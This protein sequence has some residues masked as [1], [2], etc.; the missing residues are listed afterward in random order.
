MELIRSNVLK[1]LGVYKEN[2]V[3]LRTEQ[4]VENYFSKAIKNGII[5]VDTETNNSLDPLTCLLMGACIY[6]PGEKNAYIP[7]HHTDLLGNLLPN[8]VSEEFLK[9]QFERL[10]DTFIIM[11]NGKFDY[12]VIKCTCGIA[13]HVDWDTMIGAK[14]LDE[15]ERSAGLKQQYIEKIDP[16]IEKYDIEHLF[17]IEYALVDPNIFALYAATDSFMTYKLYEWQKKIFE[18]P[19]NDRL[20]KV[21]KEIE[22]P[23]VIISAEMELTGCELDLEYSKRLSNKFHKRV[24][25]AD[26]TIKEI[27]A[28]YQPQIDSWSQTQEANFKAV[29]KTNPNKF[30]KSKVEQLDTENGK[31]SIS[32]TSPTQLAILFY[33]ILKVGIIDKK[34]PRATGEDALKE[35]AKKF[36]NY[37]PLCD[38]ILNK[39]ELEKLIN[40]YIDALPQQISKKDGRLHGQY[41]Q[42]GAK[43]GRFSSCIEENQLIEV[44]NGRKP[45]K[46]IV[47]GDLVYCYDDNGNLKVSKV[48][49]V[50]DKGYKECIDIKW[51]SSGTGKIGNLICTPDHKIRKKSGEWV[52]A[53]E[54]KRPDKLAH[55]RRN[56]NERHV[57]FYGWNGLCIL[58]EQAIKIGYFNADESMHIHHKDFNK[59][60]NDL[61][62]LQIMTGS[63]HCRLHA[64]KR[65]E[66]PNNEFDRY[67]FP[68]GYAPNVMRGKDNPGYW[69]V[70]Q[71][72][73][74]ELIIG[75]KCK[76]RDVP[77]DFNT[78]KKKI[79]ET[80]L[81]L[82][83]L[84]EEYFTSIIIK[85]DYDIDKISKELET[86]RKYVVRYM[87]K[88]GMCQ[89]HMVQRITNCGIKHVY[90]LEIE[91]Y[92]NFIASEINVHNCEPNLQNIPSGEKSIRMMFTAG[93]GN[94]L[95]GSDFS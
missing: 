33:D 25:K 21:F 10:S 52:E 78:V 85:N 11:H 9:K 20:F 87:H 19:E 71:E 91:N 64:I 46:D 72:E 63:E 51:Q 4:E 61:S 92:H 13:L 81:D 26:K 14:M 37:K 65:M 39:R 89:N 76:L 42:L 74:M 70:T 56:E 82:E 5:A 32:I 8:Q 22:M 57:K 18:R 88:Y 95:V 7:V 79:I 48:L 43:T 69:D 86:S 45:I 40:T 59:K 54:L 50:I 80:G 53:Q 6:T 12:Q 35:I 34:Q 31:L 77:R 93:K 83:A 58:E 36:P 24:E 73:L 90:D 62:N 67:K 17:D 2:T 15:N 94:L 66:D 23:I 1:I 16:S 29:N 49:N 60:N 30:D 68:K 75:A 3:C 44:V 47:P 41:K 38:A 27:L 55:L 84:K 28:G